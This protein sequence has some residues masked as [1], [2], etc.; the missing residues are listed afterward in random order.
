MPKLENS[1]TYFAKV[2]EVNDKKYGMGYEV[3]T[4]YEE[5]L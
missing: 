3:I 4:I 2:K 1:K 5:K